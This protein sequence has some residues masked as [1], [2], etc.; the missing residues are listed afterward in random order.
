MGDISNTT[1][2]V[3]LWSSSDRNVAVVFSHEGHSILIIKRKGGGLCELIDLWPHDGKPFT[4]TTHRSSYWQST[5][6]FAIVKIYKGR[7]S[8][9]ILHFH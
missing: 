4:G 2:F 3:E 8:V 6:R 1:L 7:R 5:E 9:F